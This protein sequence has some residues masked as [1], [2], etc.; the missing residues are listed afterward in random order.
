MTASW[1]DQ[2]TALRAAEA[3]A[4]VRCGVASP[5]QLR[6]LEQL[7]ADGVASLVASLGVQA[8]AQVE[9]ALVPLLER[10]ESP[11][12]RTFL[13]A[14]LAGRRWALDGRR[15][16]IGDL[17][18]P[19]LLELQYVHGARRI[20]FA[21]F[22]EGAAVAVEIDGYAWHYAT[23]EMA[24]ATLRRNQEHLA[25]GWRVLVFSARQVEEDPRGC[26]LATW[27]WLGELPF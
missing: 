2:K 5:T 14:L 9:P 16:R 20:D 8:P 17:G 18:A 25:A 3:R 11:P 26:A 7:G 6:L 4:A 23:T 21:L 1:A 19:V 12:E 15:V 13:K 22:G 10:C 24:D 27:S